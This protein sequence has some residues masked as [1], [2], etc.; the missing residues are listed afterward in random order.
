MNF[1]TLFTSV[2]I[3]TFVT[4]I[5]ASEDPTFNG[6]VNALHC[7]ATSVTLCTKDNYCVDGSR[8]LGGLWINYWIFLAE[9]G[10]SGQTPGR[11][12]GKPIQIQS[13]SSAGMNRSLFVKF[14]YPAPNQVS[15]K[16]MIA[17]VP[18][19]RGGYE[20]TFAA[21]GPLDMK[22]DDPINESGL[23]NGM[24]SGRCSIRNE[25]QW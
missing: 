22:A 5:A 18:D 14:T 19:G 11:P 7:Q 8:S 4:P 12:V 9:R 21:T 6:L 20:I 25:A 2:A 16:V 3:A 1:Q 10:I 13:V 17:L 15:H 23:V 24:R